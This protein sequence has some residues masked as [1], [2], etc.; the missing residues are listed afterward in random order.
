MHKQKM[1]NAIASDPMLGF[2]VTKKPSR[3]ATVVPSP[4]AEAKSE[5]DLTMV[6]LAGETHADQVL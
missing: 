1:R 2:G 3:A 5:N 4:L 6:L